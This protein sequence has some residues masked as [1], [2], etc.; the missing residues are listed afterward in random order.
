[1]AKWRREMAYKHITYMG[2]YSLKTWIRKIFEKEIKLPDYQR[3]FTWDLKRVED[4]KESL[5]RGYYIPPVTLAKHRDEDKNIKT[6][7]LDGQQRLTSIICLYLGVWPKNENDARDK[8]KEKSFSNFEVLQNLKLDNVKNLLE[9]PDEFREIIFTKN[10]AL[11]EKQELKIDDID[12]IFLSYCLIVP[13]LEHDEQKEK[14][15]FAETF[16]RMNT[17]GQQL[18]KKELRGTI[19]WLYKNIKQ[20]IY[21]DRVKNFEEELKKLRVFGNDSDMLGYFAIVCNSKKRAGKIM[22]NM[23]KNNKKV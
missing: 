19:F 23:K 1:M 17:L 3:E 18:S 4:L 15:L 11:E 13:N 22:E 21:T 9:R 12:N 14:E 6:F 7:L 2:A 5:E 16:R 10:D 20:D 8:N